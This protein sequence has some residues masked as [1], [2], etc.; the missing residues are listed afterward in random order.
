MF[1][2]KII[3]IWIFLFLSLSVANATHQRAG[4]ITFRHISGLTYE[5]TIVTYTYTPSPADRPELDIIWGDGTSATVSRIE[6]IDYPNDIS[7]NIY[8]SNH[9][10]PAPGNYT[11]SMED[12][13]RNY[14]VIN[15]PNSVN[16]PFYIE[17]TLIIN[18]FL[19]SNSSPVLLNPPLDN[20]CVNIPFYHNPGASDPDGDSLSYRLVFCKGLNG[21][22][23][24]GYSIPLAFSSISIDAYTGDLFWDSPVMQ[25]EYN[26]AILIEE[27]RS[28]IKI[29]SVLRDMQISIGACNNHPPI[30]QTSIDTC[31]VA[32]TQFSTLVTA[33]DPDGDQVTLTGTG[34]ALN[35]ASSPASFPQP[36]IGFG[37]VQS[38]LSWSTNCSHVRK[39]PYQF[40]FKAADNGSPISLVSFKSLRV[41]VVSPA[42]QNVTANPIGNSIKITW[43]K[44]FCSNAS[45]YKVY[46]HNGPSGWTHGYCETGVPEYTGFVLV[47]TLSTI[48][49]TT[50]TDNN[51]GLG[52]ISGN[53]YCYVVIATYPDFAESYAS[54]EVCTSLIKDV[55]IITNVSVEETDA[56]N[57]KMYIA[58]SKPTEF[59]TT[60]FPGPYEY[61]LLKS[62]SQSGTY[63]PVSSFQSL[64]DT[65]FTEN[66]IN[67]V[68]N[69]W[70]YKVEFYNRTPG[71]DLLISTSNPAESVF[72]GLSPADKK[73]MISW[74]E[75]VPWINEEYTIF[76]QNEISSLWDSI[77]TVQ[78]QFFID[79]PLV[80]GQQY[81]YY[82]RS[83]GDYTIAGTTTPLINFSQK[84][85]EIPKDNVP[86]C[87]LNLIGS[88]DCD[89]NQFSWTLPFDSC[90]TDI[91]GYYIYF[92]ATG[93]GS[94]AKIDSILVNTQ[95]TYETANFDYL[96]GC[97]AVAAFDSAYNQSV[98]SN[99]VCIDLNEC[100]PYTLP[101]VFTPN[102][103]NSN[104]FFQPF[105]YDFV[106]RINIIIFNRWGVPVFTSENPDIMWDGKDKFSHKDCSEGV[107]YYICDV[108]EYRLGG[109]KL[110]SL[111]G[112]LTLL[113]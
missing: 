92:N 37:T 60:Q 50:F 38:Q 28:G 100:S 25:G 72:I 78:Q 33:S 94:F 107:Y 19:G 84:R 51:N 61:I 31:V 64:N 109:I 69:S 5:F 36:I 16:I 44:H 6:K 63:L 49:D 43:S 24:P 89:K 74:D 95:T 52:L 112:S 90:I 12:P 59:N 9:T 26:I 55:P 73:I 106:Q 32:G 67:T 7:R 99:F 21:E 35:L 110:R 41:T 42:P 8:I 46:R 98:L 103:D 45:G 87:R 18:P 13:N 79:Q 30:I 111:K 96:A 70:F 62:A 14:G 39:Q 48:N 71:N 47:G 15:I 2:K 68:S 66:S 91:K 85:C 81:C 57:G 97:F 40:T 58:W 75:M 27:W 17:T 10:F 65:I 23:I 29:G 22:V 53:Q 83:K 34:G 102:G 88:T 104:D 101:N 4:E 105:P 82:V 20:G 1:M 93:D 77:A 76:R 108:Y 113:R 11:I 86:P 80:N 56:I 3:T 54:E